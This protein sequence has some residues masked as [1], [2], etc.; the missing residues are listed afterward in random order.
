MLSRMTVAG[1]MGTSIYVIDLLVKV[2]A[3]GVV[4]KDRRPGTAMAWLLAIFLIPGVGIVGYLLLG[5]SRLDRR[6]HARQRALNEEVTRYV[7]TLP[8]TPHPE[9]ISPVDATTI[10]LNQRLGS[11]PAVAGNRIDLISDY[12]ASIQAMTEAVD[13]AEHHVDVQFY[14][15]ADDH[16]TGPFFDALDR[17]AARGVRVRLL[18]DHLG[19]RGIPG[20]R[21]L[22]KRLDASDIAW[23]RLLPIDLLRGQIRRPDLRNHRKLLVVD[24]RVGFAGSQNLIEPGYNKPK[25]HKAGREWIELI[26]RIEGP[27]VSALNVVFASDWNTETGELLTSELAVTAPPAGDVTGQIVPSGPGVDAENNLRAFT[28]LIYAAKERISITSPYFVPDESLLYAVT[29]AARRGVAVELFVSEGKDQFM[30][31]H[32]Q[33]SYYEALLRAGVRI[34]LYPK[35]TV[36]HA[37]HFSIDDEVAVLGSSNMDMRSFALNYEI[38]LMLFDGDPVA[39]MRNVE[40][41]YRAIC[42]ELSLEE[43]L[44]RPKLAAYVDN[45]LRLTAALQ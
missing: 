8:K 39:Q 7:S 43:W 18:L 4:P 33:R 34:Y 20:W 23:R 38:S 40:D 37:K 29:T 3:L 27:L 25:N 19:S 44:A 32:A 36:L 17:A 26:A 6:R 42:R 45:V 13:G 12:G 2:I 24:G 15:T 31:Y 30:V 35:P 28:S 11:L 21:R 1:V 16:V 14:I 5:Q 22:V 41:Q 10:E 9:S